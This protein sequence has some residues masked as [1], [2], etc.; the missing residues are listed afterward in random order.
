MTKLEFDNQ[1]Y[2]IQKIVFQGEKITVRAFE[3]IVYV[4]KPV[5]E[6]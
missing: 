5:D 4:E 6:I 1:K 2:E 3:N